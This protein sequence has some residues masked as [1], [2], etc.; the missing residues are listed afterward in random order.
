MASRDASAMLC[1][2][3]APSSQRGFCSLLPRKNKPTPPSSPSR[4]QGPPPLS[5]ASSPAFVTLRSSAAMAGRGAHIVIRLVA[6][7]AEL[8]LDVGL[9]TP[10][11]ILKEQLAVQTGIQVSSTVVLSSRVSDALFRASHRQDVQKLSTLVRRARHGFVE[12]TRWGSMVAPALLPPSCTHL[13]RNSRGG[14]SGAPLRDS[15]L[16]RFTAKPRT[17][18]NAMLGWMPMA[19]G[20]AGPSGLAP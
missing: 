4:P 3:P 6:Q 5:P 8:A 13:A 7:S 11:G 10:L 9:H 19:E 16:P 12:R 18:L 2:R 14:P 17:G 20:A 1:P 15:S